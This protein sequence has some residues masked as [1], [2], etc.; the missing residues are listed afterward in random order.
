MFRRLFRVKGC[1]ARATVH[2]KLRHV[3]QPLQPM[4]LPHVEP[5]DPSSPSRTAACA[6]ANAARRL[7]WS[8]GAARLHDQARGLAGQ[9][10]EELLAQFS[11]RMACHGM[12]ISRTHMRCDPG[13]AQQQLGHALGMD[14]PCLRALAA[15]L[16]T[17]AGGA[18]A[19]QPAT[20][21]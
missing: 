2:N 16:S 1:G 14:D 13:Y 12:S 8:A 17:A 5:N 21:H 3:L 19:A 4:T 6:P 20:T 9:G 15:R 10:L 11:L 7:D 18:A